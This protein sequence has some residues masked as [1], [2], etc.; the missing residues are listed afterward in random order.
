VSAKLLFA[1]GSLVSAESAA[2]T[3]GHEMQPAAVT[4]LEGWRR[5]WSLLRD[6]EACEKTFA[7]ADDGSLPRFCL[8]LNLEPAP[9]EAGPNGVLYEASDADLDRLDARELRY[10]RIEA[11]GVVT[12]VAKA[13]HFAPEA[14]AGSVIIAAYLTTIEAAFATLGPD[15]LERFRE[16]TDHP[17]AEVIEATLVADRIPPGNPTRW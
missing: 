10:D 7:R 2:A 9:G 16:T 11:G 13:A 6:N 4:R 12:Y 15:E 3:L 8:G 5:R 1:Y 17:P 14:P